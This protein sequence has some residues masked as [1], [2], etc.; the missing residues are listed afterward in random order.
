MWSR[1]SVVRS[2]RE[3]GTPWRERY[4]VSHDAGVAGEASR[5]VS[6]ALGWGT[7]GGARLSAR[8]SVG[9][10]NGHNGCSRLWFASW[11]A[12]TFELL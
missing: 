9:V 4:R 6:P 8:F 11:F 10:I 2:L 3:P 5:L 12:E 1:V 7:A